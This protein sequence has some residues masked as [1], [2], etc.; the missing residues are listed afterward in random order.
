VSF[1][2]DGGIVTL[3]RRRPDPGYSLV[4]IPGPPRDLLDLLGA[5]PFGEIG[6]PRKGECFVYGLDNETDGCFYIGLSESL[7]TRLGV[8]Q[9][10]YGNY[11]TGIRVLRCRDAADMDV[12]ENFLIGRMQPRMN[13]N[14]TETAER[15]RRAKATRAPKPDVASWSHAL[16]EMS[17]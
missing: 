16:E 2:R 6:V 4:A 5:V 14:G 3:R 8:W 7:Y 17:S 12:T 1:R 15:R 10:T 11:L 9:K 13:V